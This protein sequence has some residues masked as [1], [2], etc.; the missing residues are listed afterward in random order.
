MI[1]TLMESHL[2]M[3]IFLPILP[4]NLTNNS[5]PQDFKTTY[6]RWLAGPWQKWYDMENTRCGESL[7]KCPAI[8][9][10]IV[11]GYQVKNCN[12]PIC[13]MKTVSLDTLGHA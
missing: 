5:L 10:E 3:S 1:S 4:Q 12:M 8:D 11:Y 6:L 7:V 9:K 2:E 13:H